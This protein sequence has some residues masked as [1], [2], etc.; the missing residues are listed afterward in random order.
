MCRILRVCVS[1]YIVP[2]TFF[3]SYFCFC[4]LCAS[5]LNVCTPQR[6]KSEN[7]L[8]FQDVNSG[9][10]SL[11]PV[12]LLTKPSCQP[13]KQSLSLNLKL[14]DIQLD[15]LSTELRGCT[16]LCLHSAGDLNSATQR[17]PR[18]TNKLFTQSYVIELSMIT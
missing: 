10:K 14:K 18:F 13:P 17:A 9:A 5:I 6:L 16:T 12:P 8:G 7:N 4:F 2:S 15:W 1:M 3:A 11:E